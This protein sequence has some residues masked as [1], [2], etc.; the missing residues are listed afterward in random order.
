MEGRKGEERKENGQKGRK[1]DHE[2][3]SRG[4][5]NEEEKEGESL[6]S[7][8]CFKCNTMNASCLPHQFPSSFP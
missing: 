5:R 3:R 1:I 8:G 6:V 4:G 2:E 7:S